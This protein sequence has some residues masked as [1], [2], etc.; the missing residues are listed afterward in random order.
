MAATSVIE[1]IA[2]SARLAARTLAGSTTKQRNQVLLNIADE[3]EK[4]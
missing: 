4:T 1:S 2:K 3:L